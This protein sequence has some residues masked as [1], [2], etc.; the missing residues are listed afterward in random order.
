MAP[1]QKLRGDET[2]PTHFQF[3]VLFINFTHGSFS[4]ALTIAYL[5]FHI[6]LS[7]LH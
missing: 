5:T 2:L 6:A 7:Q 3:E 4:K 1:N